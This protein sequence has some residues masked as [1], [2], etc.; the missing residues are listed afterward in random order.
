MVAGMPARA[1]AND[2]DWPWLPRV[3][4]TTP[5]IL[6]CDRVRRS[7]YMTPPRTLNAPVGVWFSCFTHTVQPARLPSL[8]HAYWGV[9]DITRYTSV[10]ARSSSSSV[11]RISGIGFSVKRKQ[12]VRREY[13]AGAPME[14]PA[15]RI[16]G[17]DSLYWSENS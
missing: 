17:R 5:A 7:M 1:A 3:A 4:V 11:S 8:G 12:R 14:V 2:I 16:R 10:A 13:A 6:G 15:M 9:G